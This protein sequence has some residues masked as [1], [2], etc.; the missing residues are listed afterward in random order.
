MIR[1]QRKPEKI[2]PNKQAGFTL[3]E[4]LVAL[5]IFL[6][7]FLGTVTAIIGSTYL[8]SVVKHRVQAM[9]WAQRFIEE[10]RRLPFANIVSIPATCIDI[11]TKGT[12]VPCHDNAHPTGFRVVTVKN[13]D[14][15]RKRVQILMVWT[16]KIMGGLIDQREYYSTDISNEF[17]LLN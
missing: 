3:W 12:F 4:V 10:E 15:N 8:S 17:Q 6:I 2:P 16:E 9:Y 7:L 13:V 1:E 14:A 5:S 11:D